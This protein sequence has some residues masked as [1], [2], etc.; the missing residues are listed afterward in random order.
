MKQNPYCQSE[1]KEMVKELGAHWDMDVKKWFVDRITDELK[2]YEEVKMDVP[3]TPKDSYKEKY[4]IR[5]NPIEKFWITNRK[6][7]TDIENE[8]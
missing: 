2:A 1:Y 8:E 7:A 4:S 5:W 3:Y 6:I